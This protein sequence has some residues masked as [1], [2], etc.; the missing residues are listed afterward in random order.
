MQR[1]WSSIVCGFGKGTHMDVIH[2]GIPGAANHWFSNQGQARRAA[3]LLATRLG[4]AHT[5]AHDPRPTRGLPHYHVVGPNGRRISGHFFYGRRPPRKV[6][7]GRPWR[8]Y[9]S[10][11]ELEQL[12]EAADAAINA[13]DEWDDEWDDE[14]DDW[15]GYWEAWDALPWNIRRWLLATVPGWWGLPAWR[16]RHL[17]LH[18]AGLIRWHGLHP[19]AAVLRAARS[20]H[21]PPPRRTSSRPVPQLIA[22]PRTA[23]LR[24]RPVAARRFGR[25]P[26][27]RG[28][29]GRSRMRR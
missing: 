23:S 26:T 3:L 27:R 7:R 15:T 29:G 16:F 1:R 28:G 8:E 4:S 21:L 25:V 9:E 2:P 22:R 19:R 20:L 10:E 11:A 17:L 6:L 12:L 14:Q 13:S 24:R 18:T 5:I